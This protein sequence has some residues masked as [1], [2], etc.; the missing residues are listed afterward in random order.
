MPNING[1]N[2]DDNIDVTNDNGTLNGT[3]QGTPINNVRGRGGDDDITI[4]D[5]T[6]ANNVLGNAGTDTITVTNSTIGGRLASGSDADTVDI[7]GS[8]VGNIRLGGGD[9]TLNFISTSVSGDIRG[10]SGTD[11]LNLPVGTVITDDTFGVITVEDGV[12]YSISSGTF[13]L[14]SGTTVTYSAFENGSGMPCFTRDTLIL[15]QQGPIAIQSLRTGDLIPTL[16][17]GLHPIRWIG[18]REFDRKALVDNPRL[19]PV[20][21]SAGA[22]GGG[23]PERDL[24]VS[25]Q[26]RMLVQS[27]IAQRMFGA[28]EVLIPAIKLTAMPGIYVDESV[29]SVEYFHL[30][31]D[32]HQVIF[33]EEAPTESLYTGP[34]ALKSLS[35]ASRREIFEIFPELTDL[36]Y[37]VDPA[38][39]IPRG[40]LQAQLIT[41]HLKNNK[42]LLQSVPSCATNEF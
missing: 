41:R 21:I 31:F 8:T 19:W 32:Q 24:L 28:T 17:H 10:G 38:R 42:P 20:R 1:T 3:P 40:R 5:S 7:S 13:T 25:R 4:T 34:E 12:G 14:P 39:P 15:A 9:D 33:A 23:L 18:K 26:H 16:G 29:E 22:L 37:C 6:I 35:A 2:G 30:L 11:T 36:D 27:R